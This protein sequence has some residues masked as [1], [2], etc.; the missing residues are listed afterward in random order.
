[1][2]LFGILFPSTFPPK[3]VFAGF[4]HNEMTHKKGGPPKMRTACSLINPVFY[5]LTTSKATS[6]VTSLC[7]FS[8]A[9]YEPT[10]FT[11]SFSTI[12]LRSTV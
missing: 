11:G 1:M 2:V 9:T 6:T 5:S 8:V 12:T 7:S 4:K 10:S 3:A